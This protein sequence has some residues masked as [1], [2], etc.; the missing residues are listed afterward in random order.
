MATQACKADK[1]TDIQE[2]ER[3]PA[4]RLAAFSTITVALGGFNI[5]LQAYLP[6]F[7][8]TVIG[9]DL[10]TVGLVFMTSRLLSAAA[11]PVIGWASDRTRSRF[12]RRKPWVLGGGLLFL[13]A[14][15]AVFFPPAGVGPLYLGGWLLTLCLAWTASSTPLYAWGGEM[16]SSPAERSR[17][18]AYIQTGSAA[19]IF[20][21]LILPAILDW[22]G[23][24]NPEIRTGVMGG[25]LAVVIL[26]GLA[27]IAVWF[28]EPPQRPTPDPRSG[29]DRL[30]GLR[31][32]LR[33]GMLWR[34]VLSD[35][36]VA[37]GQGFRGAVFLFFVTR[38]MGMA[39]PALLL[40]VQYAF[41]IFSAPLWVRISYRLGRVRTLIIAEAAQTAIN[42]LLLAVAP[43]RPWLFVALI[44]AQGL[45]QGS[46]N[47]MLRAMIY[48]VA[49]RHRAASGIER[50]GLFSSV[51][52]VTTN[53]AY[54]LAVGI[55]L[56][57]VGLMGFDPKAAGD[58]G[59]SAIHLFLAVGPAAGHFLSI[60]AIRKL[61]LSDS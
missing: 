7:Y 43:E 37:L 54:A 47:L 25:F 10:A 58:A 57:V 29:P 45:T 28:R 41:G 16:A 44:I 20:L 39:S 36:F 21:V 49:D 3:E 55:A 27:P 61:V 9:M 51:F 24:G 14:L 53:A 35:F 42:L 50:A 31:A 23:R 15:F 13:L 26:I 56:P 59:V 52:N 8:A 38:Y 18:Q 2:C 19:G 48:D 17:V 12:G 4:S 30:E 22:M 33:D 6:A 34:I 32:V 46:G 11:D 40:I 1:G 5:P 60:L